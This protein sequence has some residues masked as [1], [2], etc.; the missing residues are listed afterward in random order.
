MSFH[1]GGRA[2]WGRWAARL[3]ISSRRKKSWFASPN[4]KMRP[5]TWRSKPWKAV[6]E[7]L[8]NRQLAEDLIKLRAL[9]DKES[10]ALAGLLDGRP[11]T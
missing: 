4:L 8:L 2:S 7:W 6:D 9:T 10:D 1:V 3:A 11:I 5:G